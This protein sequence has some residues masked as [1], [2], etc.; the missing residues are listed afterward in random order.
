MYSASYRQF[1]PRIQW[2]YIFSIAYTV[3]TYLI[4]M[5]LFGFYCWPISRNWTI[6]TADPKMEFC[7][8]VL[9]AV[10]LNTALALSISSDLLLF[11]L[12]LILILSLG[13]RSKGEKYGVALIMLLGIVSVGCGLYRLI[14]THIHGYTNGTPLTIGSRNSYIISE[15]CSISSR[16]FMSNGWITGKGTWSLI[17]RRS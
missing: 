9:Q 8:T 1:T 16:L 10:P 2:L 12:P 11:S 5:G 14:D 3:A 13:M 15:V 17:L 7:N 4:I 6:L